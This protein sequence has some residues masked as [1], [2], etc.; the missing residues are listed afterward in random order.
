MTQSTPQ[1]RWFRRQLLCTSLTLS[2]LI[3]AGHANAEPS[4]AIQI[5]AGSLENA[6]LAIS[7]QTHQQVLFG[8]DLVAGRTAPALK[9]TY[10]AE[11][12]IKL[13]APANIAIARAGPSV[14][15]L[16]ETV[17]QTGVTARP[18]V[19]A[20]RPFGVETAPAAAEPPLSAGSVV[21]PAT[22]PASAS[23]TVS[24]V[25]V[26]GSH[27]RGATT[28]SPLLAISRTDLERSGQVTLADALKILPQNF[29]G[30]AADGNTN[31][32]G[33][34]VGRN[35]TF[36][37]ALNLRGLGNNATLVLIDGRRMAGSGTFGDFSDISTLPTAAVERVEVLL[38]GA[39]AVYGSD[40]VGGVVNII[41]RKDFDGAETR[42][43]GGV[44]AGGEPVQT[45]ISQ[46]F[47]KRWDGGGV[48]L[49]YEYQHRDVLDGADRRF[50]ASTDLRPLGGSDFRSAFAF[51]GNILA[52]ST[53]G[54]L[55]PAFAIP[56]GQNGVG[57]TAAQLRAG[58]I[59]LQNQRQGE[60][61][62]PEQSLNTVYLAAHQA[63]GDRLELTADVR[64]SVRDY[65]T[66][67][68][69]Q[70]ANLSVTRAN[71]FF[72]SPTG[73]ASESIEY[74]FAGDLPNALETG[75]VDALSATLGGTLR[76]GGD[77]RSEAY[78][79]YARE[80]DHADG[81]NFINSLALNE[82]LGTAADN[83]ATPF[84]TARDGFFNPFNGVAGANNQTALAF[85]GSG[86]TEAR[87][88]NQVS[89]VSLQA[90]GTV[91]QLPGGPLK[92]ALG[93]QAR[94]ETL[95][96]T[97]FNLLSTLTPT[98]IAPTHAARDVEGA[99]LEAQA[100]LVGPD[101]ALPGIE[102]LDLSLAGRVEHYQSIGSTANPKVGLLWA[103]NADLQV[104]ATYSTSFR[105][106]ALRELNDP[107]SLNP[108]LLSQGGVRVVSLELV[109]GNPSLRPETA[110]S[111]TGGIDFKPSRW[112][113]LT[114]S[115]TG[116]DVVFHNRI[117]RPA[118]ANIANAL[119]DPTLTSFVRHISPST[120]PADL[121]LITS[122]LAGEP[123]STFNGVFQPTDYGAIVDTRYVNTTTLHV[124]G[125]DFTGAYTFD[126]GQDHFDFA[127]NA[128]YLFQYDQQLTP[129][130]ANVDD[131]NVAN[132]PLR[133]RSRTTADWTRGR[134]TLGAA[135]N[136]LGAYHDTL[137]NHIGDQPTFDL[138]AK[139]AAPDHGPLQGLVVL[140]NVRN[141]FDR[142]PPFYNNTIGIGY[143]AAN[144]DPIGRFVS[145]QLTKT[146]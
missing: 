70:S 85:I 95:D 87:S 72:V 12:A 2:A 124:S 146:W 83:P 51:P 47:G 55:T 96:R 143:D 114:L 89:T 79:A 57:L 126:L 101:N 69:P 23:A 10:S 76:L 137:G 36:G 134:L 97:G 110:R 108:V 129:T 14:L 75:S 26:T 140:L 31:T 16:R 22:A 38:D 74:S 81:R 11:Q 5:P 29:G 104:R 15:V 145:V 121:S 68:G 61:L 27:I 139:L 17:V 78:V 46:T 90:D 48:V 131:V 40:A 18:E 4:V 30:G 135:F 7:A 127:A 116:F 138:Q 86:A 21:P 60:D 122:I 107:A 37:T 105:A 120:N 53:S 28:A 132:F 34:R 118:S 92:L 82:T 73:A 41:M 62:L 117:D 42:V 44:G 24:E 50:A 98:A 3:G 123:I 8:R 66:S 1:S 58:V 54:T 113:G 32:G 35:T 63:V 141:V 99:F 25:Q 88:Q 43:L 111:W 6:L 20:G 64:D 33:D 9:G 142:D 84:S 106:P 13:V 39:S 112:P 71:P 109:G 144:A 49:T 19:A 94:R 91:W 52:P 45:Q 65:R 56:V 77:W 128:S 59:N 119:T 115:L 103:P 125:V 67:L 136:Y 80:I 102:R 93:A 100:P 133:F 130:A